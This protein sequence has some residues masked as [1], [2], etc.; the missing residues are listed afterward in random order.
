MV[1]FWALLLGLVCM[2]F[3][4]RQLRG[5]S[6]DLDT[7]YRFL[8]MDTCTS[9]IGKGRRRMRQPE[10]QQAEQEMMLTKGKGRQ[11]HSP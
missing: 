9:L 11:G 2:Y 7:V 1:F 8:N 3:F 4:F 10:M 5:H 6:T